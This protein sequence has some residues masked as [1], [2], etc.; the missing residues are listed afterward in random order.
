MALPLNP[1]EWLKRDGVPLLMRLIMKATEMHHD[2]VCS[3]ACNNGVVFVV[4]VE[5]QSFRYLK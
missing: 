1:A 5:N 3:M 4:V 2:I